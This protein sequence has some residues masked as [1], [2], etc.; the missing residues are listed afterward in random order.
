VTSI[1]Q[2]QDY[3]RTL[4][5]GCICEILTGGQSLEHT[6]T[7]QGKVFDARWG[8]VLW[9]IEEYQVKFVAVT[10]EYTAV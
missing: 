10:T 4:S 5:Q 1:D 9:H 8:W 7:R 3:D 2:S 6:Q